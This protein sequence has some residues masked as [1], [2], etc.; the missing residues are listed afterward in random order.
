MEYMLDTANTEEIKELCDFFPLD[1]VTTNPSIL[2]AQ[3]VPISKIVPEILE[4]IGK[5]R[6]FH[7]QT[8]SE[9]AEEMV[10]ETLFYLK[11]FGVSRDYY[12]S[13]IPISA[14]GLK[15]IRI[16]KQQG[17]KTT[18]TAIITPQQAMLAAKAGA[19]Y[20]AP[21]VN[22]IDNIVSQ[23]I[24]V[25]SDIAKM[26]EHYGISTKVLSAS[27]KNADQ[28]YRVSLAGSHALTV[29]YPLLKTVLQHPLTDIA[30]TDFREKS[31]GIYDIAP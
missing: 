9:T 13:K 21:Y 24:Q 22:R 28:L 12:Y 15:A 16:L 14:D 1:G 23:G 3:G 11:S 19:D 6:M 30:I 20:V 2:A 25:V 31:R 5:E 18:A 10:K 26:F 27:F 17:V 4:I 29:S 8:I 7:F